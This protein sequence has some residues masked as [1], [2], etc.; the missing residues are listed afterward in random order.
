MYVHRLLIHSY[1]S[2]NYD[3]GGID[4]YERDFID[5]SFIT[6]PSKQKREIRRKRK[7]LKPSDDEA[8]L[9]SGSSDSVGVRKQRNSSHKKKLVVDDSSSDNEGEDPEITGCQGV[10]SETNKETAKVEERSSGKKVASEDSEE[11]EMEVSKKQS[12]K[13]T[14]LNLESDEDGIGGVREE[15]REGPKEGG[16]VSAQKRRR[17]RQPDSDEEIG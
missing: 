10:E 1:S 15:K 5:D 2:Y 11:E 6:T 4:T 3:R 9:S 17:L 13:T 14:S 7:R 16:G 12:R 8:S